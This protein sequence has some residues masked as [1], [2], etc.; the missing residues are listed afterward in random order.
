MIYS[1]HI[2]NISR[3]SLLFFS[4][5]KYIHLLK[6]LNTFFINEYMRVDQDLARTTYIIYF[7]L[8]N[9]NEV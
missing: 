8:G 5:L 6:Y 9:N 3:Q 1:P 2:I 4:P 7:L